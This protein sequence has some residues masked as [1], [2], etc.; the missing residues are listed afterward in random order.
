[1]RPGHVVRSIAMFSLLAWATGCAVKNHAY[2]SDLPSAADPNGGGNATIYVARPSIYG[3]AIK[4]PMEVNGEAVPPLRASK[5]VRVD[6]PP[7]PVEIKAKGEKM[8]TV[9]FDAAADHDYYFV[10]KVRTGWLI[11]RVQLDAVEPAIGQDA[12][13][14]CT[15]SA[16]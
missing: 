4:F 8:C 9:T 11:A 7:G 10:G 1:M 14:R 13:S 6:V 5:Y 16:E 2:G 12:T 3:F 15:V